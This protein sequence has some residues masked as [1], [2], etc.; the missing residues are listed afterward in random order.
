[1]LALAG[2]A[3]GFALASYSRAF[4][5]E[6]LWLA[7]RASARP[8]ADCSRPRG[9]VSI[10]GSLIPLRRAAHFDPA[11]SCGASDV[12]ARLDQTASRQPRPPASRLSQSSAARGHFRPVESRPRYEHKLTQ[13]F[14]MLGANLIVSSGR[15]CTIRYKR[16]RC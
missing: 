9:D 11:R 2:G 10:A 3:V 16:G 4:S 7:S 1:M 12:R 14:R 6:R 15:T 8:L 13:E 5:I